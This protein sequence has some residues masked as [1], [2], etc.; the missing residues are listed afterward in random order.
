[1]PVSS[2][3]FIAT[4]GS[5]PQVVTLALDCLLRKGER[6]A[7]VRALHTIP[8]TGAV[9][10]APDRLL[11]EFHS[12]RYPPPME[13]Q[14]LELRTSHGLLDDVDSREGA[15]A[16]F[17]ALYR[18][19]MAVRVSSSGAAGANPGHGRRRPRR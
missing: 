8:P 1:M 5:E 18:A 2:S 4:L 16:V 10:S 17:T 3:T 12:G 14:T 9:A 19:N 13:C 11:A 7:G 6:V 15:E